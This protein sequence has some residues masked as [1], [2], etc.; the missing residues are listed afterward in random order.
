MT[1]NGNLF[2]D[3]RHR[4]DALFV[5][6]RAR[7][8]Q[9][10]SKDDPGAWQDAAIA[11]MRVAADFKDAP[12]IRMSPIHSSDTAQILDAHLNE[13]AKSLRIYQSVQTPSFHKPCS[14]TRRPVKIVRLQAAGVSQLKWIP[15]AILMIKLI[16]KNQ[17]IVMVVLGI[18]LMVMF[19][20]NM[21]P[22]GSST[23]SPV[24]RQVATLGGEKITQLQLNIAADEWQT[25]KTLEFVSPISPRTNRPFLSSKSS[26]RNWPGRSSYPKIRP[27]TPLFFLLTEEAKRQGIVVSDEELE[28]I[29][30]NN[31]TPSGDPGTE[32]RQRVEDTV[33]DC[34]LIQKLANRVDRV[35]KSPSRIRPSRWRTWRGVFGQC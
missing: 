13:P 28:S 26:A 35:I 25:L 23:S 22:Q 18:V 33:R 29:I 5:L 30:T 31:V 2:V 17:K 24:L 19:V 3:A 16:R 1:T 15:R 20:A 34:L 4:S 8:G 14:P 21:G 7:E 9:A 11:F 10:L 12:G 32:E 27:G 6:A